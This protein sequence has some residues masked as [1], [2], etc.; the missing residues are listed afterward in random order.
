MMIKSLREDAEGNQ[1]VIYTGFD[2]VCEQNSNYNDD[3]N[4]MIKYDIESV[5]EDIENDFFEDFVENGTYKMEDVKSVKCV[6]VGRASSFG[7]DLGLY[8]DFEIVVGKHIESVNEADDIVNKIL[9]NVK[10]CGGYDIWL[11]VEAYSRYCKPSYFEPYGSFD[12]AEDEL[13]FTVSCEDV[14]VETDYENL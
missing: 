1:A 13:E 7:K 5:R 6:H 12:L 8:A 10:K 4:R 3:L 2:F 11:E 9:E 14:Y